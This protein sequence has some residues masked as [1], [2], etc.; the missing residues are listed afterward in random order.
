MLRKLFKLFVFL[1]VAGLAIFYLLTRPV[2]IASSEIPDAPGDVKNG[3]Y[4]FY[5]SGCVSCHAAPKAEGAE[6]LKLAGGKSFK[7]P[8]GT[9]YAPNISPD[10]DHGIGG[11]NNAQF[12][13][14][15]MRGVTPDGSHYYPAFPYTSYQRM[16]LKDVV[17]LKAYIDTLPK[18]AS[19]APS[20]DLPR[21]FRL[22][23]GLGL[24]K[25]LFMDNQPFV[26]NPEASAEINRGAYL[27]TGPGHCGECH[28]PRNL[29]GGPD[30]TWALAGGPAPEG[31]GFIP[32]I[33]PHKQGIGGWSEN[34]IVY[35]LETGFKPDFDSFG[36]SMVD[37]QENTAKLTAEDRKAIASYLKSVPAK[38]KS[39]KKK[40]N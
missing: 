34:D 3:E 37:V 22:R 1:A 39:W 23:R 24:W 21:P 7:T 33:T 32:N 35:S 18:I 38:P 19:D 26:P 25:L 4:T 17:D 14:A 28:T 13:N 16:K 11:W 30:H 6:K 5:A 15:V 9:F 20:H 2:L 27:V 29:I 10:P 36:S 8:F 12:V 40:S 31:N